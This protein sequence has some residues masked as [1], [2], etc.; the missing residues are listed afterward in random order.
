MVSH[1]S[2]PTSTGDTA[3]EVGYGVWGVGGVWLEGTS[4]GLGHCHYY[5]LDYYQV[6]DMLQTYICVHEELFNNIAPVTSF[7]VV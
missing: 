4:S 7:F 5:F 2:S 3:S 1:S 6:Y